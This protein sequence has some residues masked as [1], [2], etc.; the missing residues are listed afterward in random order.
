MKLNRPIE[1]FVQKFNIMK[2]K[3]TLMAICLLAIHINAQNSKGPEHRYFIGST[4]FILANILS[5]PPHY[6]QLNLGY[7][8]STKDEVSLEMITWTYDGP[9]GRPYGKNLNNQDSNFPGKVKSLGAGGAYKRFLWKGGYVQLHTTAF[10]QNYLD[11]SG[12]KIQRGF[13]LFNSLRLGYHFRLS[14]NTFFIEPSI[15]CTFWPINTN[16]PESFQVLEDRFPNYFIA[17]PGL[18]FGFNF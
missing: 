17:E 12:N 7:R 13:Q 8:I 6:Y 18:H 1:T 2:G 4:F 5:N 16:L 9:L 11:I 15:A 14:K 3:M 10:R